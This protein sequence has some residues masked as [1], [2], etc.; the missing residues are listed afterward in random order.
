MKN[1]VYLY[2]PSCT[3]GT[4]VLLSFYDEVFFTAL[5][6]GHGELIKQSITTVQKTNSFH[7]VMKQMYQINKLRND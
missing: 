6:R 5:V 7:C 3:D 4:K 1:I 2:L